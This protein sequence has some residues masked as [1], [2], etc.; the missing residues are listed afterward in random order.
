MDSV[1]TLLAKAR[2]AHEWEREKAP[3]LL[4]TSG[5]TAGSGNLSLTKILGTPCDEWRKRKMTGR[6]G[7]HTEASCCL[8]MTSST[9]SLMTMIAGKSTRDMAEILIEML[10]EYYG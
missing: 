2:R 7:S 4:L 9:I 1:A 6:L 8:R 3:G 10:D 5:A